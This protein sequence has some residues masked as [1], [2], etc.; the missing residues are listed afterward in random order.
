MDFDA[1]FTRQLDDLRAEGNYRIFADLERR[2]G[3]FPRAR[4]HH[5]DGERDVTIWCSND[6]LGMGQHPDVTHDSSIICV[7]KKQLEVVSM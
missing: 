2:A 3:A 7:P 1:E 4:N 6:Y 5:A